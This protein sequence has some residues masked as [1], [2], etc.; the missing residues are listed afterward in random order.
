MTDTGG[1]RGGDAMKGPRDR[2]QAA[3]EL[4]VLPDAAV[5]TSNFPPLGEAFRKGARVAMPEAERSHRPMPRPRAGAPMARACYRPVSRSGVAPGT[6]V[7]RATRTAWIDAALRTC[8]EARRE[9]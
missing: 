6:S 9:G 5:A 3:G 1:D 8:G 4:A 2:P 7:S